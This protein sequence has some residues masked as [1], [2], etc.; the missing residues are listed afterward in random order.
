MTRTRQSSNRPKWGHGKPWHRRHAIQL[1][2]QLPECKEDAL[3]ILDAAMRLVMLPG[4]WDGEPTRGAGR[5]R[6]D[7]G[8]RMRLIR[9]L[10]ARAC[11]RVSSRLAMLGQRL[12][13]F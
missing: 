13:G 12:A 5:R 6:Q 3:F 2:A 10:A 8:Q 1:A 9:L 4:F 11:F 7:R